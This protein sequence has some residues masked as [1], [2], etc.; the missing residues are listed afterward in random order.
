MRQRCGQTEST[1]HTNIVKI[2]FKF[3]IGAE[4]LQEA[5]ILKRNGII[6]Y[7]E[8]VLVRIRV[9]TK[10]SPYLINELMD[11]LHSLITM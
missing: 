5:N 3:E 1:M 4:H 7:E 8:N 6:D 10:S 2:G 9:V 11:A